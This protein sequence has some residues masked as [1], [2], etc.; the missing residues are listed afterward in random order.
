MRRASVKIINKNKVVNALKAKAKKGKV[1]Y[2]IPFGCFLHLIDFNLENRYFWIVN[3][4]LIGRDLDDEDSED[5]DE[6]SEEEM[7]KSKVT[8]NITK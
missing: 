3:Y 2:N 1:I 6:S 7:P 4:F 8:Q 5:D